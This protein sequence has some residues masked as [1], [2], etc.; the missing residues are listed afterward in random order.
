MYRDGWA[1]ERARGDRWGRGRSKA[2]RVRSGGVGAG[3]AAAEDGAVRP[4]T[5]M[6]NLL[7][8]YLLGRGAVVSA[9]SVIEVF[10]PAGVGEHAALVRRWPA[11]STGACSPANGTVVPCTS[12]STAQAEGILHDGEDRI[13]R[14]G[15][16][17]QDWDGY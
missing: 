1:D 2:R 16:V 4:Q 15:A 14:S 17:N 12:A 3:R 10:A 5:L 8:R 6:L 7:G 13:W 9:G 11:W